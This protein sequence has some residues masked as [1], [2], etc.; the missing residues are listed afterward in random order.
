MLNM[1][2]GMVSRGV[3]IDGVGLQCHFIGPDPSGAGGFSS[4]DARKFEQT[5]AALR[6][7]GLDGIV[8]EFDLRL[9]TDSTTIEGN[10]TSRQLAQQGDQ[11]RLIVATALSQSN[12]PALLT[13]GFTD[14]QSWIP[15]ACPG[16]GH[17]LPFDRSYA[18][19]PAYEGITTAIK[20]L[21]T[22][23]EN[24]ASSLTTTLPTAS[25]M[26]FGQALSNSTLSGGEGSVPGSFT[27]A[28][29]PVAPTRMKSEKRP[30][31]S[32]ASMWSASQ[33]TATEIWR[34]SSKS[35]A[36]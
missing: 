8:T 18:K 35:P 20:A 4:S 15:W 33:A 32:L 25:A 28:S 31:A 12:C 19:K 30:V 6:A 14:A 7:L 17:A 34:A 11:Y 13:W 22:V 1:V 21:P 27:F 26:T 10:V 29:P 24:K 36:Y 5:F 2:G 9:Q 23:E 3:P 16:Y